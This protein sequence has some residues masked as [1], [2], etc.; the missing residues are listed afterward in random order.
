M[1]GTYS[2][3]LLGQSYIGTY[4][5]IRLGQS[6]IKT[7]RRIELGQSY[8][9]TY[10]SLLSVLGTFT[11]VI[12]YIRVCPFYLPCARRFISLPGGIWTPLL[13]SYSVFKQVT[14]HFAEL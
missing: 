10:T 12:R 6:Y 13:N 1:G 4:S 14:G 8:I 5:R 7:Y 3:I 2:R 11:H 9:G